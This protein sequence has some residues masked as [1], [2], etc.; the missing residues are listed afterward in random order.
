[1]KPFYVVI[2]FTAV[3]FSLP[4][5][6]EIQVQKTR[7]AARNPGD[8]W[9]NAKVY[10]KFDYSIGEFCLRCFQIVILSIFHCS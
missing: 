2:A 5:E 6:E 1:M 7:N 8:L 9:P 4:L 10:Y 3:A